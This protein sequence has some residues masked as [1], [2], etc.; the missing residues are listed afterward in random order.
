MPAELKGSIPISDT[1]SLSVS[2]PA[3][4]LFLVVGQWYVE[5][6]GGDLIVRSATAALN[7]HGSIMLKVKAEA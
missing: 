1:A 2:R 5:V 6:S 3:E 4:G 7:E